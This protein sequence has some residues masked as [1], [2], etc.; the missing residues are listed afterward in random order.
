MTRLS[1]VEFEVCWA[2]LGLGELPLVLDLPSAGRTDQERKA[3]TGRVLDDLTGRGLADWRGLHPEL[4][5]QL[6][7]LAR[8]S[9]AVDTRFI[10]ATLVRARGASTGHSGVVAVHDGDHVTIRS[11]PEHAM[12]TELTALAGE[13]PNVSRTDSASVRASS[14]DAVAGADLRGLADALVARG[15]RPREAGLI[16]RMCQGA[17]ARGQFI[18]ARGRSRVVAFHD[19]PTGRYLQLRRDGWVTFT[20]AGNGRLAGQIR[21]LIG[22]S[23]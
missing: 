21:E 16:A 22:D 23:R 4:A 8:F 7:T 2:Y 11:V 15:E 13:A 18:T 1:T 20:P 10:A 12:I 6:T 5:Q 17:Y 14:L 3:I 19:T 9:W